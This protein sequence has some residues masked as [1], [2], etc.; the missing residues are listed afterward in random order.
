[1]G[2][3]YVKTDPNPATKF[4]FDDEVPEDGYILLRSI[5]AADMQ[6]ISK[7]CSKKKPP[8]YRRGTR[9]DVPPEINETL[10]SELMWDSI[11]VGWKGIVDEKDKEIPCTTDQKVEFMRTWPKFAGFVADCLEQ[12]NADTTNVQDNKIKNS[13]KSQNG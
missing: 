11:I 7:R 10:Q 3:K 1:M 6:K 8:E 12:L 4:F 9:Y 5:P 2:M 13:S